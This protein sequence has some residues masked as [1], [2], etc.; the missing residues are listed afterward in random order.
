MERREEKL[1]IEGEVVL[2]ED[3]YP[4]FVDG[5]AL[6]GFILA[7]FDPPIEGGFY[8]LGRMRITLQP[9]GEGE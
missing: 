7:H 5:D 9:L 1:V 3:G 4:T 2:E 6:G 8:R